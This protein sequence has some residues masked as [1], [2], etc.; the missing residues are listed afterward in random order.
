ML[1]SLCLSA[2]GR[3]FVSK[4]QFLTK[5]DQLQKLLQQTDEFRVLLNSGADFP[6]QHYHDVPTYPALFSMCP[7]SL[8]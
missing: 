7:R 6:S 2:L 5:H 4:M 3:Q 8:P 1:D